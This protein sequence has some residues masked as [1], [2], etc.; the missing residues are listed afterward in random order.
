MRP[1]SPSKASPRAWHASPRWLMGLLGLFL[2]ACS[3]GL[4]PGLGG[5]DASTQAFCT[6]ASQVLVAIAAVQMGQQDAQEAQRM[7]EQFA[8]DAPPDIRDDLA[9]LSKPAGE[10][11]ASEEEISAAADRVADYLVATCGLDPE[12]V[13]ENDPELQGIVAGLEQM[14]E[15]MSAAEGSTNGPAPSGP[16]PEAAQPEGDQDTAADQPFYFTLTATGDMAFVHD[17]T[18]DC[19]YLDGA[20]YLEFYPDQTSDLAYDA[21]ADMPPIQPGT[22]L[23]AFGFYTPDEARAVGPATIVITAVEPVAG[24]DAVRIVGTIQASYAGE[25]LGSGQVSG[26]WHCVMSAVEASGQ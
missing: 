8:A 3:C 2:L 12:A 9:L 24:Y 10:S 26:T 23:G 17:G 15:E 13:L 4:I 19:S 1:L 6:E 16:A 20:L 22:Y 14:S 21:Y 18:L 25:V 7:V 5:A 11:G